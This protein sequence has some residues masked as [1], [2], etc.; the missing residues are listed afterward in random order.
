MQFQRTCVYQF[1]THYFISLICIAFKI[2][3]WQ[4][5]L[6]YIYMCNKKLKRKTWIENETFL[7]VARK[8]YMYT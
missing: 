4:S 6:N 7:Q 8:S 2:F 3:D 5:F 1:N